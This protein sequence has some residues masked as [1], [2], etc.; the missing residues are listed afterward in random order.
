MFVGRLHPLQPALLPAR[1]GAGP[2][3]RLLR[4]EG[5]VRHRPVRHA[6]PGADRAD[7]GRVGRRDQEGQPRGRPRGRDA[8]G[9]AQVR[10]HDQAGRDHAPAT[11]DRPQGHGH[12][13]GPGHADAAGRRRGLHDPRRADG[14][15]RQPRRDPRQPRPRHARLPAPADRG[16]RRG[17]EGQ[18]AQLRERVP[19]VRAAQPR[20]RQAHRRADASGAGTSRG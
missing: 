17:P 15:R 8:G 7:R 2:R 16:R 12:R 19:P 4:A 11:E 18:R 5:G 6:R 13:D 20:C 1:L 14:A 3:H 10:R 9:P